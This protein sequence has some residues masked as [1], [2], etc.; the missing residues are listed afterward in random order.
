MINPGLPSGSIQM[1]LNGIVKIRLMV[2]LSLVLQL[3]V[4]CVTMYVIVLFSLSLRKPKIM[5]NTCH[6][7]NMQI[8]DLHGHTEPHV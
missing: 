8:S 7:D 6:T 3:S 4:L 1:Y 2:I 5:H